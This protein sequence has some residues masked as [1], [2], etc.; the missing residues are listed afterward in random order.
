M[1]EDSDA[2]PLWQSAVAFG[3]LLFIAIGTVTT[4]FQT[5]LSASKEQAQ[6]QDAALASRLELIR[7][8]N[9]ESDARLSGELGRRENEIKAQIKAIQDE[10]D[11]R[12][13]EFVTQREFKQF[14]ARAIADLLTIKEQLRVLEQTRPT[15]GELSAISKIVAE[16]TIR[17]DERLRQ[18]EQNML[19][20]VK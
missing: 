13:V 15:T 8:T 16:Q 14:Q 3:S 7:R 20:P 6:L 19:R 18:V 9:Q 1:A 4:V 2:R 10:L 12:R 11:R 17:L 5:Q